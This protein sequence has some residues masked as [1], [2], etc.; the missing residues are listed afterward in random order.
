MGQ[1]AQT[2]LAVAKRTFYLF[3]D[4]LRGMSV[5]SVTG[6]VGEFLSEAGFF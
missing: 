6:T 1:A 5:A 2:F 3:W 4:Y